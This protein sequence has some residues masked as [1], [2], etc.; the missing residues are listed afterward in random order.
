MTLTQTDV[1]TQLEIDVT[2]P[3]FLATPLP[4]QYAHYYEENED[5]PDMMRVFDAIMGE[6]GQSLLEKVLNYQVQGG[7]VV[8]TYCAHIPD[9][10]IYA[11]GAI[12]LGLCSAN[13]TFAE[14]GEQFMPP[15]T[16]PLVRASIGAR[17][18][19]SCPYASTADLL[20]GETSC[21]AKTK[22]WAIMEEDADMHVIYLPKRKEQEDF[23]H[24]KK[25]LWLMKEKLE[26]V[27]G[28]E[29][30][31]ESLAQ[32]IAILNDQKRAINRMWDFRKGDLV[33]ISGKDCLIV[34]QCAA[35]VSPK[36]FAEL[37]HQLCDELQDRVDRGISLV[38]DSTPRLLI[39]G[40]PT[41]MQAWAI[42]SMI[43]RSG[44]MVVVEETCASTRTYERLVSEE[45]NSL[46]DMLANLTEKYF[47][48][49]HCACFTP[50][51]GRLEDVER[52]SREYQADGVLDI[53]LKFCQIFDTEHYFLSKYLT[54]KNIPNISLEVD[55]GDDDSGQMLTRIQAFLE[56]IV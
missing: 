27:T 56:M 30:T 14:M 34:Q 37:V 22:A 41:G 50:N 32:S 42:N 49:I 6:Y 8:G 54:E 39:T 48:G 26:S 23:D 10:L 24:F 18:T 11:A 46:D 28:F 4:D 44:G 36:Q 33:P 19:H 21:D 15:N 51:P 7:K 13:A 43:E 45:A 3:E 35:Y 53:H 31:E 29:V 47:N 52:L 20:I 5:R 25:E 38:D 1:W 40:S 16:C 2:D 55:Y 17:M 9:D 12:P